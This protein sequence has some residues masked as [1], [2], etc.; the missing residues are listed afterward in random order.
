MAAPKKFI[1]TWR[2]NGVVT[3]TLE[4]LTA[5][6]AYA[7][8]VPPEALR[9]DPCNRWHVLMRHAALERM[10]NAIENSIIHVAWQDQPQ[11]PGL[12]VESITITLDY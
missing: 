5:E 9:P 1:V 3:Y 8:A 10:R 2:V 11:T 7:E 4:N 12:D 6:Q